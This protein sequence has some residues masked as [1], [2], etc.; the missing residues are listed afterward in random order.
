MKRGEFPQIDK[1]IYRT[2]TA[3]YGEKL[4]A[5]LLISGMMQGCT[6]TQFLLKVL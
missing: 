3:N 5:F 4:D 6:F 2:P 1:N